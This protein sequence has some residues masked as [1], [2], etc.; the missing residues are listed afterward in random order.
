MKKA[1]EYGNL[2]E[3]GILVDK[4]VKAAD[5]AFGLTEEEKCIIV[6]CA[7]DGVHKILDRRYKKLKKKGFVHRTEI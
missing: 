7:F 2:N 3:F 6:E 5:T 1:C 4:L